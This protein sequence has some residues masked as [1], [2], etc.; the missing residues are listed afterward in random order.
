VT[1]RYI[2][3]FDSIAGDISY[4]FSLRNYEAQEELAFRTAYSP[5]IA[6]DYA[7][8]HL[9]YSRASKGLATISIRATSVETSEANLEAEIDEAQGELE[10]IGVGYL[11]RLESDGSTRRRCI[12][13]VE[14]RPSI[15]RAGFQS[16]HMPMIF[17]FTRLTDWFAT[18]A[19]TGSATVT[20]SPYLLTVTNAGNIWVKSG[21]VL[22]LTALAAAGLTNPSVRNYTTGQTVSSTRGS[23]VPY[24]SWKLDSGV[25]VSFSRATGLLIG[26]VTSWIGASGMG[27]RS[28]RNDSA[29]VTL[30]TQQGL[31]WLKPGANQIEISVDGTPNYSLAYTFNG[32]FV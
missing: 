8:D 14:A 20:T 5:G 22:T 4:T 3:R 27:N 23:Q 28:Y 19:T 10:N 26:S 6:A 31:L 18:S 15:T 11:Y 30:G 13:R 1:V 29:L 12:A 2:E 32:A 25:G 17:K 21:F 16:V 9:G 7:H 24:S